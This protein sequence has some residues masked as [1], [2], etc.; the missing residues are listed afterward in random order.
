MPGL[1]VDSTVFVVDDD[2]GVRKSL[3]WLIGSTGLAVESCATARAFL[4]SYDPTR[5]GCLVLDMRMPDMSGLELQEELNA[6]GISIPIIMVTAYGDVASAV[7][8]LKMGA[9][10]FIEKPFSDQMLL[11]SVH[12]AVDMDRKIR[13]SRA[14][15]ADVAVRLTRLTTREREVLDLLIASKA[16]KV[17][18]AELG[19]SEK[20]IEFHRANI[21]RK[22]GMA[23]FAD[24]LFM[25]ISQRATEEALQDLL[26]RVVRAPASSPSPR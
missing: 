5:P 12:R 24:V 26:D 9:V 6:R 21:I 4:D 20:T 10:D 14:Q 7:R 23:S 13:R 22:L 17:I 1:N 25:V 11:D 19:I 2:E 15:S 16:S 8:A 3:Q 18:V